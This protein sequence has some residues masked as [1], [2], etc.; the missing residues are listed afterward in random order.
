[1]DMVILATVTRVTA[2]R[3]TATRGMVTRDMVIRDTVTR[4]TPQV[5]TVILDMEETLGMEITDMAPTMERPMEL[6]NMVIFASFRAKC[7]EF[8]RE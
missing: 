8:F 2:I 7:N 1:M 5:P 3:A 6:D 4:A